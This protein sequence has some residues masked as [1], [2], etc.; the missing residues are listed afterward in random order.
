MAD[1]A[2]A[3]AGGLGPRAVSDYHDRG[4]SLRRG[5]AA[6]LDGALPRSDADERH[7]ASAAVR[8]RQAPA[9][10]RFS[11]AASETMDASRAGWSFPLASPGA[12]QKPAGKRALSGRL[13]LMSREST[14]TCWTLILC[15]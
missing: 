9:V 6:G 3:V 5:D 8:S 1:R 14:F 10:R 7:L 13:H 4:R 2:V 15:P 11:L 12:K